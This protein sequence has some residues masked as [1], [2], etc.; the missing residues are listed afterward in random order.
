[1]GEERKRGREGERKKRESSRERRDGGGDSGGDGDAKIERHIARGDC[2]KNRNGYTLEHLCC[3][4][5]WCLYHLVSPY[6]DRDRE[7]C[8]TVLFRVG[9]SHHWNLFVSSSGTKEKEKEDTREMKNGQTN[10]HV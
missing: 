2:K 4:I 3:S 7:L 9:S 1:L 8:C 10:I 5:E 6:L